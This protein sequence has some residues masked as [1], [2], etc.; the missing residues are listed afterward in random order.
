MLKIILNISKTIFADILSA[1]YSRIYKIHFQSKSQLVVTTIG[2]KFFEIKYHQHC[3]SFFIQLQEI[4]FL[5]LRNV[6]IV[7]YHLVHHKCEGISR[8]KTS[9]KLLRIAQAREILRYILCKLC[10]GREVKLLNDS[11]LSV[12]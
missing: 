1:A 7:I 4:F 2:E 3:V 12:N 8:A 5:A 6:C 10:S 11:T 9:S